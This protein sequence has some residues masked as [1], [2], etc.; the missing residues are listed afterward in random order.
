MEAKIGV[1]QSSSNTSCGLPTNLAARF[2]TPTSGPGGLTIFGRSSKTL[3][4]SVCVNRRSDQANGFF[5]SSYAPLAIGDPSQGISDVRV[6]R[7][8]GPQAAKRLD[9]AE[10]ISTPTSGRKF[11]D[12]GVNAY[13]GFYDDALA[14]MKSKDLKAF[15]LSE[16]V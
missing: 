3:P 11:N 7:R 12:K 15:D 4:A 10:R 2:F 1:H 16:R 9:I 13:N 6:N 8:E 14:L 5:P